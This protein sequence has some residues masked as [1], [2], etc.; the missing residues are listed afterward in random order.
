MEACKHFFYKH[1]PL[2]MYTVAGALSTLVNWVTYAC[3]TNILPIPSSKILITTSNIIAWF[4]TLIFAYVFYKNWVFESKTDSLHDLMRELLSFTGARLVTGVIE[5][6]GV[7]FL[8]ALGMDHTIMGVQGFAAKICVTLI[9]T[10]LNYVF[11]KMFVFKKH[12]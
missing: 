6:F 11:S 5:V 12:A 1:K 3:C 8:V 9:V 7:P 2:I 4:V 10:I